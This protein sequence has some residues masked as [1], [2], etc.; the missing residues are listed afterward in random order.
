MD[1]I[2]LCPKLRLWRSVMT[3]KC[4]SKKINLNTLLPEFA[5][6]IYKLF[7]E[8]F[9]EQYCF[10]NVNSFYGTLTFSIATPTN[11]S[12]EKVTK[13]LYD[14]G[15]HLYEHDGVCPEGSNG[16]VYTLGN[17]LKIIVYDHYDHED[18]FKDKSTHSLYADYLNDH[19]DMVRFCRALNTGMDQ[20]ATI[21]IFHAL[22]EV[23]NNGEKE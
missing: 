5:D 12:H 14:M 17:L 16:V 4:G 7:K 21:N 3:K 6:S 1:S 22:S 9:T 11:V 13:I 18:F 8:T 2:Y 20:L 15:F 23:I 10:V 19:P